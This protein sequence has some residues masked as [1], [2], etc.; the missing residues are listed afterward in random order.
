MD[1]VS[2]CSD[3]EDSDDGETVESTRKFVTNYDPQPRKLP[4]TSSGRVQG[5][6]K[7]TIMQEPEAF[8]DCTSI[9]L[10]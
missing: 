5:E 3:I 9:S 2:M 6:E 8:S 7:S 10:I 4:T 1:L